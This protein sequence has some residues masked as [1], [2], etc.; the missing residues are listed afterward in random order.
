MK[1]FFANIL[2]VI[3]LAATSQERF[4]DIDGQKFR[5]KTLG[6]GDI[7]VLFE[8]GMSD[9]L[10]VWQSIPDSVA[11][12]AKVFLYDRADIGKSDLSRQ[13]RS[14]PNMVSELKS[15]LKKENIKPPY[16]LVGH[17]LGGLIDRYFAYEYPEE[18]SGM[19][20][21]DPS[22]ESY[23]KSMSKKK[24]KKYIEGGTE[25]YESRFKVKYRK[26][27]YQF[28]PNLNYMNNLK[29]PKDM[30]IILLSAKQLEWSKYQPDIIEGF[31]NAKLVELEGDHYTHLAHAELTINWIKE[32]IERTDY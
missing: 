12:F 8:N 26:E 7:T 18:V 9:S 14:I 2:I 16:I 5:I 20:L 30:P 11:K 21:L 19:L 1:T 17:S 29:I 13:E 31:A 23:W 27:W 28:I 24:L 6:D 22:A 25:W 3:S 4:T 15:I 10:E 32:L